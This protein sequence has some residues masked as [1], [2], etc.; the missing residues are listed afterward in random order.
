MIELFFIKLK[1]G[2]YVFNK[3][4]LISL[5]LSL[6]LSLNLSAQEDTVELTASQLTAFR[7]H[8]SAH[9]VT[10]AKSKKYAVLQTS[11]LN[12]NCTAGVYFDVDAD[13]K[14]WSLVLSAYLAKS[15]VRIGYEP[16]L[17]A[18]WGDPAYC[19]LTYFDIR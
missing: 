10:I 9:A 5:I 12:V 14:T 19:Q 15:D 7:I 2:G 1:T 17:G 8:T 3:K 16:N 13:E 6:S 18:P 11:E 4:C